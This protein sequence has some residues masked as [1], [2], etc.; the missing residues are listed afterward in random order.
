MSCAVL[1]RYMYCQL[2]VVQIRICESVFR[3]VEYQMTA[4]TMDDISS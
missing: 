1:T 2:Q 4:T 3:L